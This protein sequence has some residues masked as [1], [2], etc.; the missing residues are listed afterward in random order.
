MVLPSSACT[1][2]FGSGSSGV[3]LPRVARTKSTT[4]SASVHRIL[5]SRFETSF[6]NL[7]NIEVDDLC[8]LLRAHA[9]ECVRIGQS[10]QRL[11]LRLRAAM[12]A[13]RVLYQEMHQDHGLTGLNGD[14][15]RIRVE[16]LARDE[17]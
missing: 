17:I 14:R 7:R 10:N 4:I 11:R 9:H 12:V 6:A 2:K 13:V 16:V 3:A 5:P 8:F 1:S 15:P